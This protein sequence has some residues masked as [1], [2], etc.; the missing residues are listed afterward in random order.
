MRSYKL[1]TKFNF[2]KYKDKFEKETIEL[3]AS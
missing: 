2:R 3:P 1:D